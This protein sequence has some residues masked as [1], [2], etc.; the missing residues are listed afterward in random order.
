MNVLFIHSYLESLGVEYLSSYL[1]RNGHEVE[2]FFDPRT[3]DNSFLKIE[4]L[5]KHFDTTPYLL[6]HLKRFKPDIAAFSITTYDFQWALKKAH[7]VKEFNSDV[8]VIFG[9]THPTLCPEVVISKPEVDALCIGEGELP[10]LM[11]VENINKK[12]LNYQIPNL[13]IKDG[14]RIIKNK[15][16]FINEDLDTLPL[17]DKNLFYEINPPLQR[18][19]YILHGRGCPFGCSYCR[20]NVL[21]KYYKNRKYVRRR[22]V[23]NVIRELIQAKKDYN[24]KEIHFPD[25][26]FGLGDEDYLKD[27]LRQ[28]S[29]EVNVPFK[30]NSH[31]R[32]LTEDICRLLKEANCIYIQIGVQTVDESY[33]TNILHRPE[34]NKDYVKAVRLLRKYN[35]T[36]SLDHIL[37]MP[38]EKEESYKKAALFYNKLRPNFIGVFWLGY[39]PNTDMTKF[40][41]KEGILSEQDNQSICE[42]LTAFRISAAEMGGKDY[43]NKHKKYYNYWFWM[44]ILPLIPEKI[45]DSLF[46]RLYKWPKKPPVIIVRIIRIL[47]KIRIGDTFLF[48]H[49]IALCIAGIR[50]YY[51]RKL[52]MKKRAG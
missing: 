22:S 44:E 37:N 27:L 12:D 9:G 8:R 42:G 51:Y 30:I 1:K 33:R 26:I 6:D 3:F 5:S 21:H 28:Y 43:F 48:L 50:K 20:H 36:F 49:N 7:L 16:L 2:L 10:L 45:F 19:Y 52:R 47:N 34:K 4:R 14:E 29:R 13:W 11:Y 35:L 38:L 46:N 18:I 31:S 25:A 23:D 17:P 41:L 15:V 39:F 24:I 32:F 40:A